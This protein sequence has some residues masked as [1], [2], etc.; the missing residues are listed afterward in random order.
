M[1]PRRG[2]PDDDEVRPMLL[3]AL[4]LIGICGVAGGT[5][6]ASR[7]RV[8]A[9]QRERRQWE[10]AYERRPLRWFYDLPRPFGPLRLSVEGSRLVVDRGTFLVHD[11]VELS[12]LQLLELRCGD[13]V[14]GMAKARSGVRLQLSALQAPA[15]E[16]HRLILVRHLRPMGLLFGMAELRLVSDG[17]E[18]VIPFA[19]QEGWE[20]AAEWFLRLQSAIGEAASPVSVLPKPYALPLTPYQRPG[21]PLPRRVSPSPAAAKDRA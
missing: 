11:E 9:R 15:N 5:L 10:A 21:L 4:A 6:L 19:D 13:E 12:R 1:L 8:P 2:T 20:I 18:L 7:K 3:N 14:I 17:N 16:L